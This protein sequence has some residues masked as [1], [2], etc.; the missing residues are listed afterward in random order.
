M[1]IE[2]ISTKTEPVVI[3]NSTDSVIPARQEARIRIGRLR[4]MAYSFGIYFFGLLLM[5]VNAGM[6]SEYPSMSLASEVIQAVI[7]IGMVLLFM[8]L[9]QRR[10]NDVDLSGWFMLM[11]LIPIANL[12]LT[13]ILLFWP[14]TTGDNRFGPKPEKNTFFVAVIGILVL[15]A[16]LNTLLAD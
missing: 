15:L 12:V 14:G 13:F 3:E 7:F 9:M 10:L 6:G 11:A 8:A 4:Y 1:S 2:N 5:S 16:V